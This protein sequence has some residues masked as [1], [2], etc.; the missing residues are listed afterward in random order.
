MASHISWRPVYLVPFQL[1][2]NL[3]FRKMIKSLLSIVNA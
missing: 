1:A 3:H 2:F